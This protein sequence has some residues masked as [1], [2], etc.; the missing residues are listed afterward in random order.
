MFD[1]SKK[2]PPCDIDADMCANLTAALI[3]N[4]LNAASILINILH[5]VV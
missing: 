2:L 4:V 5:L 3:L 1:L